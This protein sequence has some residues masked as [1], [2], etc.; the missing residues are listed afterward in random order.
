M[1]NHTEFRATVPL[2][3][4][5]NWSI[6]DT[7]PDISEGL[8]FSGHSFHQDLPPGYRVPAVAAGHLKLIAGPEDGALGT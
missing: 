7:F 5:Q 4:W 3:H 1:V 6:P 2:F 8:Y